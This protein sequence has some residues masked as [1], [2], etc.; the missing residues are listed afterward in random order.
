MGQKRVEL[1]QPQQKTVL[2]ARPS[3]NIS[4]RI[5]PPFRFFGWFEHGC[6]RRPLLPNPPL[7]PS[8]PQFEGLSKR[9]LLFRICN[10]IAPFL[11]L[12]YRSVL[13][14]F[15]ALHQCSLGPKYGFG[16]GNR[17]KKDNDSNIVRSRETPLSE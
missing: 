16:I 12:L 8:I 4:F 7:P 10:N 5:D 14:F 9:R 17:C 13:S 2:P 6:F 3:S 11:F 1:Q 15:C